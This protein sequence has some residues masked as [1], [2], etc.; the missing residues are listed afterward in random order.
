MRV[1]KAGIVGLA[2]NTGQ[3]LNVGD[4]WQDPRFSKENDLKTGY[5]TKTIL[6]E[7][8]KKHGQVIAAFQCINKLSPTGFD[9]EDIKTC[10]FIS[11]MLSD[12]I[13]SQMTET[14]VQAL[15]ERTDVHQDAK[16]ALQFY[17]PTRAD[18]KQLWRKVR[19]KV[20]QL[21]R[22]SEEKFRCI[23]NAVDPS[24]LLSWDFDYFIPDSHTSFPL[25]AIGGLRVFDFLREFDISHT[26]LQTFV[27]NIRDSYAANPYHNWVHGFATFHLAVLLSKS[28]VGND[29]DGHD[30][31]QVARV[32]ARVD[33]LALLLASLGHDAD[34]R[35]RTNG[36]ETAMQ[37]ELATRYNDKAPLENHH[38]AVTCNLLQGSQPAL[39]AC[40]CRDDAKRLREVVIHSI[41]HTDMERHQE[42]VTWLNINSVKACSS[43]E[44]DLV[45]SRETCASLLH[46]ADVGHPSLSWRIHKRFSLQACQ[47]FYMQYQQESRQGF[48]SVP[49][50]SKD[51]NGPLK[52]LAPSQAGFVNFVVFPLWTALNT[53]S[54]DLFQNAVANVKKNKS[55]WD[56][57]AA[58]EDVPDQ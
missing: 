26:T 50:M 5:R 24:K 43:K 31:L 40:M 2:V 11:D 47:E 44:V 37:T 4:A 1:R 3:T 14:S 39:V 8:F 22:Q 49:F 18:P 34:H 7:P 17:T 35:G 21:R 57:V 46:S 30:R 27:T 45:A 33:H 10:Q 9:A 36:F 25:F 55:L 16:A 52:E 13:V 53:F 6:C 19:P 29:D 15:M 56:C 38:A 51:P 54:G 42:I 23:V 58:G 48:P 28:L 41:L 32:V 20:N 12:L